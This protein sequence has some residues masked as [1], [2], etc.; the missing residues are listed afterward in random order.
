MLFEEYMC[1]SCPYVYD[2]EFGDE[3]GGIF[4]NTS[5]EYL[6][7]DWV[8][9]ICG[10]PKK[11]FESLNH[12]FEADILERTKKVAQQ[13]ELERS[14]KKRKELRKNKIKNYYKK[15]FTWPFTKNK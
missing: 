14:L 2:P 6:P 3:Y 11:N 13:K 15:V 12:D 10:S 1:L 8:Y 7:D 4:P 9:P 5:F